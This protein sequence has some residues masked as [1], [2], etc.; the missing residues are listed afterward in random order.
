MLAIMNNDSLKLLTAGLF[1]VLAGLGAYIYGRL[2]TDTVELPVNS[3]PSGSELYEQFEP[4]F[5]DVEDPNYTPS[6]PPDRNLPEVQ[7]I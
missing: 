6:Y 7:I 3:A 5:P 4:D 2:F 1:I